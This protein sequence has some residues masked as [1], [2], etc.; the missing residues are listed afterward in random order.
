LNEV[1]LDPKTNENHD[2]DLVI[3]IE[4]IGKALRRMTTAHWIALLVSFRAGR[5]GES[6]V[7]GKDPADF[8]T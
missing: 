1:K 5:F 7:Q 8:I 6:A 3:F 2:K 4:H